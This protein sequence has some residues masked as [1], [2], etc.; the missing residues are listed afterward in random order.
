MIITPTSHS[1]TIS[2]CP[3]EGLESERDRSQA[4][5]MKEDGASDVETIGN[6]AHCCNDSHKERIKTIET[7]FPEIGGTKTESERSG[8]YT[9]VAIA[10][11]DEGKARSEGGDLSLSD[12]SRDDD[13][14]IDGIFDG[15]RLS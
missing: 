5:S 6:Y 10:V 12:H 3:A 4:D 9:Q 7:T 11:V 2:E 14:D 8:D 13:G 1:I 15:H